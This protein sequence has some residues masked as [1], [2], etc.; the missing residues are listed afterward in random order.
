MGSIYAID[1]VDESEC[2]QLEL[3]GKNREGGGLVCNERCHTL[4]MTGQQL[5]GNDGAGRSS[6]DNGGPVARKVHYQSLS[7]VGVGLQAVLEVLLAGEKAL[8][9]SAAVPA[10][11]SEVGGQKSGRGVEHATPT[12]GTG[13]E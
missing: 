2:L 1:V 13:Y 8:R 3:L 4:G 6:E 7:I 10:H 12:V 5:L 9:V 11:N